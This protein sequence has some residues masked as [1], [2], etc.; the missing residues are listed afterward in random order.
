MKN[1]LLLSLTLS[2]LVLLPGCK[3]S[4]GGPAVGPRPAPAKPLS[5][6]VKA[7][8]MVDIAQLPN[9]AI[10]KANARLIAQI[11]INAV[12]TNL[13]GS[14]KYNT[15]RNTRR[16]ELAKLGRQ[17][18]DVSA[19]DEHKTR[20]RPVRL[21]RRAYFTVREHLTVENCNAQDDKR[22]NKISGLSDDDKKFGAIHAVERNRLNLAKNN[23]SKPIFSVARRVGETHY[24][25]IIF[26]RVHLNRLILAHFDNKAEMR[27]RTSGTLYSAL[28]AGKFAILQNREVDTIKL[29]PLG[30]HWRLDSI[31]MRI[32]GKSQQLLHVQLDDG[33]LKL[34]LEVQGKKTV[35]NSTLDDLKTTARDKREMELRRLKDANPTISEALIDALLPQEYFTNPL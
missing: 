22:L 5:S 11:A 29:K 1:T 34:T 14:E 3:I 9:V 24:K 10:S 20:Y 2:S 25:D 35:I 32:A 30:N 21:P 28:L 26:Q 6:E 18:S 8:A 17:H 23:D 15:L 7:P 19:C 27:S 4:S 12:S 31:N 16:N 33:N 13:P